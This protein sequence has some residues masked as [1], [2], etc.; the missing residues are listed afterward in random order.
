[1]TAVYAILN[2]Q[3]RGEGM[4]R[5]I[6]V[7]GAGHGGLTAAA[8][9]AG[10]GFDVTVFEKGERESLGHDWE[11]CTVL[12]S[13]EFA[14]IEPPP[15]RLLRPMGPISYFSPSKSVLL[16][17]ED[18]SLSSTIVYIDRKELLAHL[19]GI[20]EK[21]GVNFRFGEEVTGPVIKNGR[22]SGIKTDKGEY[23]CG[24]LIDAAGVLSPVR[25]NLP[26]EAGI[27]RMPDEKDMLHTFRAL[28]ERNGESSSLPQYCA[29]FYH[30]G[31]RG[32]D[33]VIDEKTHADVLVASF[34]KINDEIRDSA[35]EDFRKDHK[36]IGEKLLRGGY[37]A[38]IPVRRA[39]AKFVWNGYAAIGDSASMI[40]PLSGSGISQ[41][42]EAGRLLADTVAGIEGGEYTE[43]NLYKY[44]Y[45]YFR[46]F[47]RN[48]L[49]DEATRLLMMEAGVKRLDTMFDKRIITGKEMYGG[50]YTFKDIALKAAGIISSP[51]VIPLLCRIWIRNMKIPGLYKTLP[52]EYD[53]KAL[54]KWENK[55][56]RF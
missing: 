41:S 53:E 5:K 6:I 13:F 12:S 24:L 16:R 47:M 30:N 29:Y 34:E 51:S 27:C 40:E 49:R 39:L 15:A 38:L 21:A 44:E 42:I 54:R 28:Y 37:Y 45:E 43:K 48:Q 4:K 11:D 31:N 46:R 33:W 22:T 50:R 3:K 9:L 19:I 8:L 56:N 25:M 2:I 32:F 14:G 18:E 26:G 20:C 10:K 7:A 52:R 1:M 23:D 55:Y 17:S 36:Y 35:L